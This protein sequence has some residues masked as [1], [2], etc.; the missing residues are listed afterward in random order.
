[1][2]SSVFD[3]TMAQVK[4][5]K[6]S[7]RSMQIRAIEYWMNVEYNFRH[8]GFFFIKNPALGDTWSRWNSYVA[9]SESA[10]NLDES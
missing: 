7:S 2:T 4:L 9:V 6:F 10:V 8:E 3:D 1:V 5:Q